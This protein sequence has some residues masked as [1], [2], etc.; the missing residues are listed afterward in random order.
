MKNVADI[1]PLTPA[2]AG[3]LFHTLQAPD[4]GVY[5]EQYVCTLSGRLDIDAFHQAWHTV[6]HRHAV[7]RTEFIWEGIDEPLQVVRLT[8]DI[9]FVH[10]D[11]RKLTSAEKRDRLATH[12]RQDRLHGFDPAKAPLIRLALFQL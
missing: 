10:Q 3:I 2:Q 7:L 11:W 5:F 4:S 9:P 8:V 12:L 6:V 1:Y